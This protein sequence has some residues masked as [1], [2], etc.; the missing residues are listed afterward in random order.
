MTNPPD[1]LPDQ[2]RAACKTLAQQG[3]TITFP[4]VAEQAGVSRATLYRRRDLRA[5]VDAYRDP[6][7]DALTITALATQLDQLRQTLAALAD[8]VRRHEEDLRAL[9]RV[10]HPKTK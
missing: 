9:K 3:E 4:K 2:V 1:A 10:S 6:T 5:I 7:G 8:N